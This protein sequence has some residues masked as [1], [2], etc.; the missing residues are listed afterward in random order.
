MKG[1]VRWHR[2][3]WGSRRRIMKESLVAKKVAVDSIDRRGIKDE[4]KDVT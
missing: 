2:E 3:D 4:R 1:S